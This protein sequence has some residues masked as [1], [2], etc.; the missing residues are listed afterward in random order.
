MPLDKDVLTTGEVAKICNVAPRT[1]SKWF[2]SGQLKGYRIPGS[3]DRRIPVAELYRFMKEH[4]IP[5]DGITS[6]QTRVLIV[7]SDAE[8]V[9]AL[10][11]VLVEQT[12]YEVQTATTGFQAGLECERFRPHVVLI[13]VHLTDTDASNITNM[14]RSSSSM[15]MT[16]IIAM[17]GKLTDGQAQSLRQSG[18]DSFLKKPFQVRQVVDSIE[19]VTSLA[20]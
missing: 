7:D 16:R 20:A 11:R 1:V 13:D 15:Q 4:Q 12:N 14:I 3:K 18:Y 2:D 8:I 5:M 19:N 10:E 6:G 9:D 17:S